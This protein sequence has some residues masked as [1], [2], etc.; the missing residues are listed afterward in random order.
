[1]EEVTYGE[2]VESR[3]WGFYI[4]KKRADTLRYPLVLIGTFI[5]VLLARHILGHSVG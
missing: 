1:M 4:K 2:L 5:L 3:T